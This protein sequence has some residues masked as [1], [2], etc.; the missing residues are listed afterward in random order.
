MPP[1]DDLDTTTRVLKRAQYEAFAFA[2]DAT[3]DPPSVVVRNESH[4]D[5]S[6]D[7]YRVTI[8][9]G[10]PTACE[11]P[12]DQH[13]EGACKHRVAIAI[14]DRL[15]RAACTALQTSAGDQ[16]LLLEPT[17]DRTPYDDHDA[18]TGRAAC[19]RGRRSP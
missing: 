12:A 14:R 4:A 18:D 7:E 10:V 8:T 5:P 2:I 19:N 3:T 1:L 17:P 11:C 6:D 13:Y 15:L 9:D 16:P